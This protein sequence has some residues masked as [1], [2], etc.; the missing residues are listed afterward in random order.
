MIKESKEIVI[1]RIFDAPRK[2]VWK[3]ITDK[4]QKEV[5]YYWKKLSADPKSEQ[6]GWLKD[7]YGLSWQIIPAALNELLG[8]DRSGRVTQAMLQMKK[9]DIKKLEQAARKDY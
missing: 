6:C 3:A 7:K 4:D 5:D 8:K 2:L 9:I 1:E